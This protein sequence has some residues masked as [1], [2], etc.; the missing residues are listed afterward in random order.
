MAHRKGLGKLRIHMEE[1]E[2]VPDQSGLFKLYSPD[3]TLEREFKES[4]KYNLF[5]YNIREL[6]KGRYFCFH[7][8]LDLFKFFTNKVTMA[9]N[10]EF[11]GNLVMTKV[12]KFNSPEQTINDKTTC[13]EN[14][15][16]IGSM[17]IELEQL[18]NQ[19][20]EVQASS[21]FLAVT[22]RTSDRDFLTLQD[23]LGLEFHGET[24]ANAFP[25]CLMA[26]LRGSPI[27]SLEE[28]GEGGLIFRYKDEEALAG[29]LKKWAKMRSAKT[30]EKNPQRAAVEVNPSSRDYELLVYLE[31]S[32]LS[33]MSQSASSGINQVAEEL[34]K[35]SE[36]V[37]LRGFGFL[38]KFSSRLALFRTLLS[39]GLLRLHRLKISEDNLSYYS[40]G[41]MLDFSSYKGLPCLTEK[42]LLSL[43]CSM[44]G[45]NA[46]RKTDL[47][48]ILK[49]PRIHQVEVDWNGDLVIIFE[50]EEKLN[51]MLQNQKTKRG[52]LMRQEPACS[53]VPEAGL[54]I[55]ESTRGQELNVRD[56][57]E[58]GEQ[59]SSLQ[60]GKVAS[61]SKVFL[62]RALQNDRLRDIYP[63]LAISQKNVRF[64]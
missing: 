55:L 41:R 64:N 30:V 42:E 18:K 44:Q 50:T 45:N 40:R 1:L 43:C 2:L 59:C 3:T 14:E 58:A 5:N 21:C 10:L 8:K 23:I 20:A 29:H 22:G 19:L 26:F 61:R 51:I 52:R 24:E 11:E 15:V 9:M 38:A 53:L 54:F 56:F 16:K 33:E 48:L 62:G 27:L 35:S 46:V 36:N 47:S 12:E 57:L 6:K 28:G 31:E 63:T 60:P 4:E 25:A 37:Q 13:S 39:P 32:G 49:D 34:K 7:S 17:R